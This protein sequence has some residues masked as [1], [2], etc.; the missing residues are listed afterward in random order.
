MTPELRQKIFELAVKDGL[1]KEISELNDVDDQILILY[2]ETKLYVNGEIKCEKFFEITD[3]LGKTTVSHPI[4][5]YINE[6]YEEAT[7]RR[8]AQEPKNNSN[9]SIHN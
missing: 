8:K 3:D 7:T 4:L 2:H 6:S 1:A 9:K 5:A